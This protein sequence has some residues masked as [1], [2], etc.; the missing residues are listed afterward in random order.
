LS[1]RLVKDPPSPASPRLALTIKQAAELVN[2]HPETFRRIC[3]RGELPVVRIGSRV[4]ILPR[5]LEAWL[6]RQRYPAT[7]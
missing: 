4:R 3:T 1:A 5:D 6:E 2:L 7:A